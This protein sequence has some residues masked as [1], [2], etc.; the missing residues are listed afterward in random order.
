MKITNRFNLPEAIRKACEFNEHRKAD[1]SVTELLKAPQEIAQAI[2][3]DKFL[4]DDCMDRI[5]AIFGSACHKVL[6][7]KD[8]QGVENE[9]YMVA[10]VGLY[11]VSGSADVIDFNKKQIQDYKTCSAWKFRLSDADFTDWR[12]Q[13]RGYL[14][15]LYATRGE[16]FLKGEI[17]AILRDWSQTEA[18]RS[19]DYPQ[20]PVQVVGFSYTQDEIMSVPN[21]WLEKI[22]DVVDC[23]H[24]IYWGR[25]IGFCSDKDC[26]TTPTTY[27]VM[28]EGRKSAVKVFDSEGEA[29][30]FAKDND[31]Y[32]VKREGEHRK[33]KNYC[34]IARNGYCRGKV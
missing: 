32:V 17:V 12:E 11:K 22:H 3:L 15:L 2:I 19:A 23:I 16:L 4:E 30:A 8:V 33:C 34:L 24:N 13:L 9:V 21:Q 25:E 6:E 10:H 14:Y 5:W 28:K 27:A 20:K 29:E 1:F 7:E 26:W 18:G 31:Y